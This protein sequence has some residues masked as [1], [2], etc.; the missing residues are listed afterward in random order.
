LKQAQVPLEFIMRR[1]NRVAVIV[2]V[3]FGCA[4]FGGVRTAVAADSTPP[5]VAWSTPT[6]G[7]TVAG[8]VTLSATATDAVGVVKVRFWAGATYLGYDMVA[9]YSR[10]WNTA[11][12]QNGRYTL[13]TEALDAAGNSVKKTITVTVIN[14]DSVPPIVSLMSPANGAAVSGAVTISANATDAKGMQKVRF[15]SGSTYLGYDST[16]PYSMAWNSSGALN[17]T[18]TI[19]AQAVD[20]ANNATDT[21]ISVNVCNPA[22]SCGSPPPSIAGC[23]VFPQANAWNTDIS[24]AP[25]HP[26]SANFIASIGTSGNGFLHADFGSNPDY[27]IPYI[28]VPQNQPMTPINFT[29]YGDE[30][31]PGPYPIPLNAPIESGSDHHVLALQQ[32]TCKLYEL[33]AASPGAS[34]WNAESGA[35]WDLN[36]GALR[37]AGWTSADAAGLPILPG[38]AR[39]D[40]VQSGEITH[41][42]RVTVGQT[43]K[44]YILPATHWAST[45]TNPNRPPMGLRLRL[46]PDF[47][48]AGYSGD[49]LVILKAAK[50]Y[51][52][53][54]ADNG[55]SWYI[56]GS[57]DP[58]WDDDDLDQLKTVPGSAFEAV[59]TGPIVTP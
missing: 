10:T 2:T 6:N 13:T 55:T 49:A 47:D 37:P 14:P 57:R 52:L 7:A 24:N 53:I 48:L 36:T 32:G 34:Q 46:R 28:V 56:T 54:I 58:R 8:N 4:L 51:G 41:A 5:S 19:R 22:S 44:G 39:Y 16:A 42:L 11:P 31:D 18:R 50:K 43:Q 12:L 3:A 20:W 9:P 30:S 35:I 15:W 59:Y 26:N 1:A 29:A 17:G 40:E 27:G 45:I 25:V 38:L 23:Q 33:F 21:Q